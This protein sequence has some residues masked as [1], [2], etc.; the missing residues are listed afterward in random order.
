MNKAHKVTPPLPF[1]SSRTSVLDLRRRWPRI[2]PIVQMSG[3]RNLLH[4]SLREYMSSRKQHYIVNH[5][6]PGQDTSKLFR[7]TKKR[8]PIGYSI[9]DGWAY[10]RS[11]APDSVG[12]FQVTGA[13][14]FLAD[15]AI[16]VAA[17]YMPHLRWEIRRSVLHS[18]VVGCE[19]SGE[20]RWIF[21]IL[22]FEKCTAKKLVDWTRE[23]NP[24]APKLG[25]R[26]RRKSPRRMSA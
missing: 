17:I 20:I 6:Q 13:C 23:T 4:R 9:R 14:H 16:V 22:W 26:N 8:R 1:A 10:G 24:V 19:P 7:Y 3:I 5:A 12:W 18:T 2:R 11:P 25:L 15:W 21:D